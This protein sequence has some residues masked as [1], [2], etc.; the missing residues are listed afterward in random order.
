VGLLALARAWPGRICAPMPCF[1]AASIPDGTIPNGIKGVCRV[2]PAFRSAVKV[3]STN[4][5][6]PA[7]SGSDDGGFITGQTIL[8]NGGTG[9]Y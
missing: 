1:P 3:M 2:Q 4:L 5:P 6:P 8:V 7:R 9:Y